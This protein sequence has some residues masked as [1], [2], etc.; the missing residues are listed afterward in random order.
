[1]T[2]GADT[3]VAVVT[4]QTNTDTI[5]ASGA[6]TVDQ[7]RQALTTPI[8]IDNDEYA[9]VEG[10]IV[11]DERDNTKKFYGAGAIFNFQA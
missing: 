9:I 2:R 5:A 7:H 3:A 4:A 8:W 6:K 11:A 1:V 10:S